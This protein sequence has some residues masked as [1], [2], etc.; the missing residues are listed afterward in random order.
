VEA[1]NDIPR[2]LK[3]TMEFINRTGFPAVAFLL[4]TYICFTSL[5]KLTDALNQNTAILA[6]IKQDLAQHQIWAE[7]AVQRLQKRDR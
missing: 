2:T 7:G 4:M 1:I 5:N 3:W 6:T